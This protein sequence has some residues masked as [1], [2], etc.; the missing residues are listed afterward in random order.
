MPSPGP[1][2]PR[3]MSTT[4]ATVSSPHTTAPST[5]RRFRYVSA[6]TVGMS[7]PARPIVVSGIP[8][9]RMMARAMRQ[10]GG[11]CGPACHAHAGRDTPSASQIRVGPASVIDSVCSSS[12]WLQNWHGCTRKSR[13]TAVIHAALS[14]GIGTCVPDEA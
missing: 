3:S 12:A 10:T 4:S 5:Q 13:S 1:S 9:H 14:A 8:T 2:T 11:R 6:A 7:H